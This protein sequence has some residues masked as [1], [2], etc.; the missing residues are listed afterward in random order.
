M[1][2]FTVWTNYI[3]KRAR[4]HLITNMVLHKTSCQIWGTIELHRD[5]FQK[6][7]Q[8]DKKGSKHPMLSISMADND[9]SCKKIEKK[10]P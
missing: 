8:S 9:I 7:S 5:R 3:T 2:S 4:D 1:Y 6:C 10:T